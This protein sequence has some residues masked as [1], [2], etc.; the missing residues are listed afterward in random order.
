MPCGSQW[1]FARFTV[2]LMHYTSLVADNGCKATSAAVARTRY[3]F[4][5]VRPCLAPQ[6]DCDYTLV[7]QPD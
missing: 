1:W 5:F 4:A 3:P 2:C 7:I 6:D